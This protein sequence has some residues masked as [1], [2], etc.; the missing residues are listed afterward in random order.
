MT[1]EIQLLRQIAEDVVDIRTKL[2]LLEVTFNEM[3]TDLHEVRPEYI[4]KLK[5]IEA[6]G[7]ISQ[8]EFESKFGVTI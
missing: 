1:A 2:T 5:K 7:T 8:E 6:E 3:E 4:E